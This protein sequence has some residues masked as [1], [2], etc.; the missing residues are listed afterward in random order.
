LEDNSPKNTLHNFPNDYDDIQNDPI[1]IKNYQEIS[2]S[3]LHDP[4]DL[5]KIMKENNTTKKII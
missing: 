1:R 3:I 5:Q 2:Q 4:S